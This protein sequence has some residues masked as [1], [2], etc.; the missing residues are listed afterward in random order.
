[1][2][3]DTFAGIAPASVPLFIVF[4]CIGAALGVGLAL[5]LYPDTT[6]A[7]DVLVPYTTDG[8][9]ASTVERNTR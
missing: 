2:F 3:S 8:V 7:D 9:T 4:Q 5:L 1:M 6:A